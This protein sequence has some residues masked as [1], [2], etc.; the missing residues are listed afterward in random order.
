MTL[1]FPL[2]ALYLS[3]PLAACLAAVPVTGHAATAALGGIEGLPSEFEAH[4]YEVPLAVRVDLDGRYLGDAMVV[5]S[6][7]QRV[8]LLEFT[9]TVDSREPESLR[10]RWRERLVEGRPLGDCQADCP[11][12]LRA[13]HYSLANSQL[14]LLTDQA[15]ASTADERYHRLPEQ[16]SY[17]LLVRNQLNLV[18]DGRVTSGRYALQGQGSLGNWTTLADGQ[19]DR[20]SDSQ[21]G[22]RYRVDQLYGERLVQDHFYRLGYFTP[23]A[24]GLTRQPRLMGASPD[25]TLGLMFGSSDSLATD[26]GAPSATPIYVTPN[27]P[28]VAEIYRNG[29][30]INS[31]PVQP[32]LQTLDSK[33]LPGGIYEVE[34]RLVEDGQVTSRSQAF[35]YKPGNWRSTDAPWRYNL[36]L[37]RQSSLLS[38]WQRDADDSL[39]AGVLANY[40]VHPRAILGVSAQRIDQTLQ[41]GTSLDWDVRDRFKL[42][43][44]LFQ[45]QGYGNGY[46]LQM[47]HA[48]EN[49]SLVASQSST[50]LTRPESL[51]DDRQPSRWQARQTQT[52]VSYNHRLDPRNTASVRVSHS[53]GAS[54]GTGVDLGWSYFGQLLGSQTN[55]RL[56][57]FDRP[58]NAGTGEARSRGVNLSLSM[59][60]GGTSGRR[61]SASVGSRTARDGGRDLNAAV[62]YQQDVDLGPLR[63]VGLTASADRYGAGLGG[64]TQFESQQL[65]GDAYFQR[66]SYN[67]EF[68]GGLNL[69]SML[70]VGAGKA[71]VSGQ[72]LPHQAGLIVD[73]E[74]DI[75][76]L[77]LRADD[78]HGGA[79]NLRPGR[80]LVPVAAYKAGNVQFDL[81]GA[82]ATAAVIQPSS[83]D[84]H[85]NR[86]GIGYRQLRVLRTLTV[87]GRLLDSQ[88]RPLRGA[89]V[90]NH[91]S[92]SVS[93]A[94]GFFAVE[95][96]ESTPS[97]EVRQQ[98]QVVCLLT[99]N[100][101]QLVRE[102]D[103]LLAGDQRCTPASLAKAADNGGEPVES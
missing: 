6:R 4:F 59:S 20:G 39:A 50:W 13:V 26:N 37:G 90:I 86:G 32:G 96:S 7:D 46:D 9:E 41:Y 80:N 69:E 35:I 93:E 71:A 52:S 44:N 98:G 42:Y 3:L 73:V 103:V 67:G 33:V 61:L 63:S 91:A 5:L 88:G 48:G 51:R 68:S 99:L 16:G 89:Q 22:T 83:V 58:G 45:A 29:V 12:G 78:R 40:L 25:T 55:W 65:H 97:L 21:Q 2:S 76:G 70:A 31:Q 14:S 100:L 60:L 19:L 62:A 74:T 47:I 36:Y 34:I 95:M 49:S 85:L 75:Q 56:S 30:L 28:A 38:N 24:Q 15:E 101:T 84:Y 27:R 18:N 43:G 11:D 1:Q 53:S 64:D 17:G 54:A 77:K 81:E 82:Q 79:A 23:S 87:I 66:S 102:D 57:L 8:Q 72:Y 94:D 92:R 10:R